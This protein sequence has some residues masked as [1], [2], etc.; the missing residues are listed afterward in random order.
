MTFNPIISY[1]RRK[2][3]HHTTLFHYIYL[4]YKIKLIIK[5]NLMIDTKNIFR[6]I[7]DKEE[8]SKEYAEKN[9]TIDSDQLR[10][11]AVESSIDRLI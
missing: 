7:E 5:K 8:L 4:Y 6:K 10:R 1:I 11:K 9:L 2:I 3:V